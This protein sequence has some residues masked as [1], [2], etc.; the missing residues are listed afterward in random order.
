MPECDVFV[1][2]GANVGL[3]TCLA[4]AAGKQV[5]AIE[6]HRMNV[7]LL[8]RSIEANGWDDV[9]VWPVGVAA[10]AGVMTLYGGATGASL[11]R[12]WA[13]VS[14]AF[15]QTIPVTTLD[16]LLARRFD[17]ARLFVKMDIEGA[18]L[19]ALQGANALLQ[20]T[21]KPQWLMEITLTQNRET[22][23]PHFAETFAMFF[24]NGYR[25]TTADAEER[26]VTREDIARW[27]GEPA[28]AP[29]TYNWLFTC[30]QPATSNQ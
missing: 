12:G 21:P 5:I 18:E 19:P 29:T 10:E 1:D 28:T 7:Q 23:N 27:V 25:C 26:A 15:R 8:F 24:E 11:V 4:R 14:D 13:G 2:V 9:E 30:Q 16:T 3:Y 20:R 22:P 17:G 6:P